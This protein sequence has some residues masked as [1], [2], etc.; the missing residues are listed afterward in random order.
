[1][2]QAALARRPIGAPVMLDLLAAAEEISSD[3]DKS[4]VLLAV[5]GRPELKEPAVRTR[6]FDVLKTVSSSS[7]YRRVMESVVQR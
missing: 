4:T 7:D 3:H 6:F 2:L 1:V 5:A